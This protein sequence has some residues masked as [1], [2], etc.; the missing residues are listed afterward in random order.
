MVSTRLRVAPEVKPE[1]KPAIPSPGIVS[2][3]LRPWLD[4]EFS[5]LAASFD[6]KQGVIQFDVTLFNSGSAPARDILLEARLFNAGADQDEVIG[7]FFENPTVDGERLDM[8]RA[9][10]YVST[11]EKRA[12]V[13]L[14]QSRQARCGVG[15]GEG[16]RTLVVSLEGFCSTIELHPHPS[17]GAP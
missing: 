4:I 15:A 12:V 6:E 10:L 11:R 2:A 9:D 8:W 14:R 1:V 17:G 3:R 16:N 13:R 5:P 7:K